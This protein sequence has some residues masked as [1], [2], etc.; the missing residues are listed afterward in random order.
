MQP[1]S[2]WAF[3]AALGVLT[4]GAPSQAEAN[5]KG[6]PEIGLS[7]GSRACVL[8]KDVTAIT[9]TQSIKGAGPA[10]RRS[11]SADGGIVVLKLLDEQSASDAGWN[12][13]R[14]RGREVCQ[15]YRDEYL[16]KIA[17]PGNPFMVVVMTWGETPGKRIVITKEPSRGPSGIGNLS[18][19]RKTIST[20]TL[21]RVYLTKN[22]WVRK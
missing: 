7:D 17:R 15:R 10:A 9:A 14:K 16:Q 4:F 1:F 20:N 3:V 8:K 5:C 11:S 6:Q 12:G 19:H 22:C 18:V 13:V 2:R 21:K